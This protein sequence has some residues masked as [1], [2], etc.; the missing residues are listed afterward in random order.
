MAAAPFKVCIPS[1]GKCVGI[2]AHSYD[3]LC[4][5]LRTRYKICGD[6][7]LQQDDGTLV[8]DDDYFELL[9]PNTKLTVVDSERTLS[10]DAH[11]YSKTAGTSCQSEVLYICVVTR[12]QRR[13][14]VVIVC[15]LA[16]Q[17]SV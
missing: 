16:L 6:F 17:V 7:C 3:H 10:E 15:A 1:C 11:P 5:V 2:A 14:T 9:E 13:L 8:C 12:W 4:E